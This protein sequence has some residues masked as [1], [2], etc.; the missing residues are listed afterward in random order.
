[1]DDSAVS[2]DFAKSTQ[3]E[4][5]K[6]PHLLHVFP[7][8]GHGG[9]PIRIATVINHFGDRYRHTILALDGNKA[10]E[11]RLDGALNVVVRDPKIDKKRPIGALCQ[12]RKTLV[13]QSP[14]LLLT[15]N[16]GSVEWALIN[17]LSPVAPHVHFESG[18]GPEEADCQ[19]ARRVWARRFALAR[20]KALV[21]PSRTLVSIASDIWCVQKDKI[22]HIANG[23]DCTLFA[24]AGDEAAAPG[25][26]RRDGELI[27]GTV[28]PLRVEKNLHRLIRA[29]AAIADRH[30]TRL[31]IAGDG[32]ERPALENTASELGVTDRVVFTG[33]V[34]KPERV[35]P[36][37]DIFAISSD[38]EQMPNTLIQAMAASRPVAGVDVGDVKANLPPENRVEIVAKTDE[39]GFAA[40]L[41]RLLAD[42]KLRASLSAAN[43]KHVVD[44]Y[45]SQ[46]MFL[47][48]GRIFDEALGA[49]PKL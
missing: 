47:N 21:V 33:H 44:Q 11:S 35:Y 6:A 27:I 3:K 15:Y 43:R 8:Y 5:A 4:A 7:S 22:R 45:S 41:D 40:L 36:L 16:W 9:V 1:M 37:M 19:I 30:D 18:F 42:K 14:D 2:L 29:F 31:L 26:T 32:V 38:T 24:A 12:I 39:S 48:Y 13:D 34:E 17:C 20:I 28:A 23:V 46:R 10:A 49:I 25:F